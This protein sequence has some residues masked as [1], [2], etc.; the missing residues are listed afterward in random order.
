METI[1]QLISQI[2]SNRAIMTLL[3]TLIIAITLGELFDILKDRVKFS[4][5]PGTIS[6]ELI[7]IV[8]IVA[9]GDARVGLEILRRAG[10]K[11]ES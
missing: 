7:K 10:R 5:R 1:S 9:D 8:F 6:R 3:L 4:F 11:A 2:A